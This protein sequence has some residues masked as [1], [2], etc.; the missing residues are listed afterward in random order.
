FRARRLRGR[1]ERHLC[2]RQRPTKWA[3]ESRDWR[4]AAGVP[5]IKIDLSY[6]FDHRQLLFDRPLLEDGEN[7]EDLGGDSIHADPFHVVLR[8]TPDKFDPARELV[9]V[10]VI[11][12]GT[13]R[14]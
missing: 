11:V 5:V 12:R 7:G 13:A 9:L 1:V 14:R 4:I 2:A 8:E 3:F 10:R 6:P